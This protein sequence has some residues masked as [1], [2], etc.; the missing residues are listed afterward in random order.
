MIFNN[1]GKFCKYFRSEVLGLTLDEMSKQVNVKKATLSSF[2]ND[3]STNYK[4]LIKYYN[5]G[6]DKQKMFFRNNLPL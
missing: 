3:R 5:C 2:E 6:D 1:V 4:H